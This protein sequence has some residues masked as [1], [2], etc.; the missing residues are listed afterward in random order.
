MGPKMGPKMGVVWALSV[1]CLGFVWMADFWV[2]LILPTF[3]AMA[4]FWLTNCL[5][6]VWIS[7]YSK[8]QPSNQTLAVYIKY[9]DC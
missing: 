2:F 1:R 3:F 6:F 5:G 4:D 8:S 7:I 9:I